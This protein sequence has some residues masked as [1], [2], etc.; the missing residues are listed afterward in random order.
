MW[1]SAQGAGLW[2]QRWW[3]QF[4]VR[5]IILCPA[6]TYLSVLSSICSA[7]EE[8]HHYWGT[9]LWLAGISSWGFCIIYLVLHKLGMNTLSTEFHGLEGL[10]F[11]YLVGD[12]LVG[13]LLVGFQ[14]V[15]FL[16]IEIVLAPHFIVTVVE[17]KSL[18]LPHVLKLLLPVSEDMRAVKYF[19]FNNSFFVSINFHGDCG[20]VM[21]FR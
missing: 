19:H 10:A 8:C 7:E 1:L 9:K 4:L 13:D 11:Y 14:D 16:P 2:R 5:L 3:V 6:A 21:K 18:G 12:L 15:A 17:V 20:T